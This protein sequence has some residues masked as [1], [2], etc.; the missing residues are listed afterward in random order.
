M[1][2]L[3]GI[4]P[5]TSSMPWKERIRNL[6]PAKYLK[7]GLVGKNRK[8]RRFLLPSCYQESCYQIAT[9]YQQPS[10]SGLRRADRG[11]SAPPHIHAG[12]AIYLGSYLVIF[13][14]RPRG[15][16]SFR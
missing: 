3:V 7:V 8:N 13:Q 6:L 10:T 4:E 5:T 15:S 11:G 12:I 16:R 2:D 1:V 9:N 14:P